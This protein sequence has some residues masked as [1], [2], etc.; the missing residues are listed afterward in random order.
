MFITRIAKDKGSD[1]AR[2][3]AGHKSVTTTERYIHFTLDELL[4]EEYN[5]KKTKRDTTNSVDQTLINA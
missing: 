5:N 1:I 3:R 4:K 2:L